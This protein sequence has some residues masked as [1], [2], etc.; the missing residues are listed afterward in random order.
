LLSH[1]GISGVTRARQGVAREV[2]HQGL[3]RIEVIR[4]LNDELGIPIARAVQIA[5]SIGSTDVDVST[6]YTLPSGFR[7]SMPVAEIE[8]RLRE[9]LVDA[10]DTVAHVR[11]GRPKS[12]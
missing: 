8:R 7:L 10:I 12:S 3:V 6:A 1:F 2:S 4:A 9:Q 5:E 11:R